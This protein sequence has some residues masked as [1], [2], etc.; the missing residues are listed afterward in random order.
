MICEKDV[1]IQQKDNI[2]KNLSEKCEYLEAT[3]RQNQ[4]EADTKLQR[5]QE[6]IVRLEAALKK[7]A[8]SK[9]FEMSELDEPGPS[10]RF[11]PRR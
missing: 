4:Y 6:Q 11:F 3:I 2:I 7:G 1:V 8:A 10:T 5:A 9:N